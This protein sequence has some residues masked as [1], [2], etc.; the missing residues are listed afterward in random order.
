MTEQ[1]SLNLRAPLK[2]H[3]EG[4]SVCHHRIALPD[5]VLFAQ[6]VQTA[7]DRVARV[8]LGQGVNSQSGRK[9]SEIKRLC[10]LDIVEIRAGSLAVICDL[11]VQSQAV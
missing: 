11:P 1:T 4:P 6:Q 3:L 7:V 9:S 8:L 5:F 2:I 10:S